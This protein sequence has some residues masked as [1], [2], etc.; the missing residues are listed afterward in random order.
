MR[1]RLVAIPVGIAALILAAPVT[2]TAIAGDLGSGDPSITIES[3][4][5]LG[6]C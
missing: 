5:G 2:S 3:R 4:D 1:K 6:C